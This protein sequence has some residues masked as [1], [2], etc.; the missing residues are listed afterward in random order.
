[1]LFTT[2]CLYFHCSRPR[3]ANTNLGATL[4]D[5]WDW[6]RVARLKQQLARTTEAIN[7]QI[8]CKKA[9]SRL[10]L[11]RGAC[12]AVRPPLAARIPRS[13][14]A[15]L[16]NYKVSLL[17]NS[18]IVKFTSQLGLPIQRVATSLPSFASAADWKE[19]L[20]NTRQSGID[21]SAYCVEWNLP[22]ALLLQP[23]R[24]G[25]RD[26]RLNDP[27]GRQTT[28][29]ANPRRTEQGGS[30]CRAGVNRKRHHLACTPVLHRCTLMHTAQVSNQSTTVTQTKHRYFQST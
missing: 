27:N 30:S 25:D 23:V 16:R 3:A 18:E 24:F 7:C 2:H 19:C 20:S 8:I 11:S 6:V 10:R 17:F 29:T 4:Q 15:R 21:G 1:M 13:V 9:Y 28:G 14:A 22:R 26:E 5:I 12:F